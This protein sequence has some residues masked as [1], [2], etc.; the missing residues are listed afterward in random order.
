M[1]RIKASADDPLAL[2][3]AGFALFDMY[4]ERR[5]D[6]YAD[7]VYR[8]TK[9]KD[10]TTFGTSD[11]RETR[12]LPPNHKFGSNDVILLTL[13]PGGSGD[14]FEQ[15]SFPTSS[16]AVSVEARVLS[17]GPT[18]VDIAL[19]GGSFEAAF[20]P[21]PNNAGSSGK[22][23]PRMR[24][25][26]DHFFSNVPYTRMVAALSQITSLPTKASKKAEEGDA[27]EQP[28]DKISMDELL[29]DTILSTFALNDPS[30]DCFRDTDACNLR[31][32][33]KNL[34]KPPLASSPKL[35]KQVLSYI[36]SNPYGTFSRFNGPQ[37]TAFEAAQTRRLTL[38]QGPPG[39]SQTGWRA[40]F[41][42]AL[43]SDHQ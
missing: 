24:L 8:L 25:R 39:K 30:S 17:T 16:M 6:L 11:D 32:L 18:Y 28:H 36:S 34:A 42:P 27:E 35:A 10:A 1:G 7:E 40:R 37:L 23:D 43:V 33:A 22:G 21:A 15:R 9:A 29:R 12:E 20:G 38:I 19:P 31:D 13:Q 26:A 5:G 4:P 14:F 41:L 3:A 2:E